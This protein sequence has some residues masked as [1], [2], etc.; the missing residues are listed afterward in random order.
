MTPFDLT[1]TIV[2][3]CLQLSE[4]ETL[5]RDTA[6]MGSFPEFNSLTI[7]TMILQIEE[8]TGCDIEDDEISADIFETIG[9]LTD[10]VEEKI[11]QA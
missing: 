1:C 3:A 4:T 11:A 10:F 9:T 7:V 2:R 6:L 5:D 8:N